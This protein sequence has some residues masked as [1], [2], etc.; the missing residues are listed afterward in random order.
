MGNNEGKTVIRLE[1]S[2]FHDVGAKNIW[3]GG[4]FCFSLYFIRVKYFFSMKCNEAI[5]KLNIL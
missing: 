4:G 1:P 3:G 2:S 5:L